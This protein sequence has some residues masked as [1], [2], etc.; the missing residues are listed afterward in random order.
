[1]WEDGLGSEHK[2]VVQVLFGCGV[3]AG[4]KLIGCRS[5]VSENVG[6]PL[7]FFWSLN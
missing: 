3:A 5:R 7:A 2:G 4:S 1:M 6:R